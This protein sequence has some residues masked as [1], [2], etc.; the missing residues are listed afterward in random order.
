MISVSSC[1]VFHNIQLLGFSGSACV[2]LCG[3]GREGRRMGRIN[4]LRVLYPLASCWFPDPVAVLL[5]LR[6]Q[7]FS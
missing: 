5:G 6:L 3:K 2:A 1:S 7:L 4:E